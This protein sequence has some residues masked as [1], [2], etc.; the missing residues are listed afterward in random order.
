MHYDAIV[1][2]AGPGGN[3]TAERLLRGGRRVAL[4]E[5]HRLGGTCLN[6]G[7]MPTKAMLAGAELYHRTQVADAFGLHVERHG[8]DGRRFMKRIAETVSFL[9]QAIENK[10]QDLNGLEIIEGRGRLHDEHTV[11][12]DGRGESRSITA[13]NIIIATGSQPNRPEFLP[14]DS[15]RVMTNAQAVNRDD[16]PESLLVL[17]GGPLGCEFACLYAELGLSVTLVEMSDRLLPR[18][19][20]D[21]GEAAERSLT[22]RGVR[23]ICGQTVE[24]AVDTGT[25]LQLTL[26]DASSHTVDAA[27]VAAGRH[28]NIENLGLDALGVEQANGIIRVDERC[29]TSVPYIYAVGDVA[30][31]RQHSHLAARMGRIAAEN[32]LGLDVSDDRSIVPAGVY[33]HPEIAC[34]GLCGEDASDT[35]PANVVSFCYDFEEGGMAMLQERRGGRVKVLADRQTGRIHGASWIGPHAIDLIHSLVLAMRHELT[36]ADIDK[37]IHAHPSYAEAVRGIAEDWRRQRSEP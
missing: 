23:V 12:V 25:A 24:R 21:A 36:L 17:G 33:V 9:Q 19:I 7:C 28:A 22:Q 2:G 14:W 16:L 31:T 29:R 5:A 30:E 37:A 27:L 18:L 3:A 11:T 10:L 35:L 13:E 8:V 32:C 15:H 26:S 6:V 20:G 4:I 34:V 1:I